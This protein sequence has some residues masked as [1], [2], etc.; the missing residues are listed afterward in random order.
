M[1]EEKPTWISEHTPEEVLKTDLFRFN[2]K[3]PQATEPVVVD[4]ANDIEIDYDRLEEQ[5]DRCPGEYMWWAAM[6]SEAKSMVTLLELRLKI[7]RGQLISKSLQAA[8]ENNVKFT[9]KQITAIVDKDEHLLRW[10][11]ELAKMHKK[12]GK[13][14]HM[15]QAI[16]MKAELLRS[17]A[18]FKRQE[19]R[20]ST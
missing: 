8:H 13:L 15:I 18:G 4:I 9:D 11:I 17:R 20:H 5:I 14:W 7:R 1:N 6:Y 16:L 3:L 19:Y 12:V 2:I 10:E